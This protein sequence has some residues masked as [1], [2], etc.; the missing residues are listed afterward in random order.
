M[1][2]RS[3]KQLNQDLEDLRAALSVAGFDPDLLL[4]EYRAFLKTPDNVPLPMGVTQNNVDY[5]DD[6]VSFAHLISSDF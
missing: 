4:S 2:K 3:I 1:G 5:P 6:N